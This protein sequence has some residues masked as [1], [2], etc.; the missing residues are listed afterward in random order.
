MS[1]AADDRYGSAAAAAG[2]PAAVYAGVPVHEWESRLAVPRFAA[3]ETVGSTLDAAHV[4]A[5]AGAQGGT[6]VVAAHQ[7]AG[8]GR[9]GRRWSS[10]A[11]TGVW[12]TLVERDVDP[13]ALGVLSLRAGLAAAAALDAFTDEPIR[14]KWPNDLYLRTGKLAG[15]LVEARWRGPAL[16]WVAIGF[17]VNLHVPADYPGAAALEPG[18]AAERVLETLVPAL[19]AAATA[20]GEL[21]VGELE[22][23]AGRDLARG[24]RCS[25]PARGR[26]AGISPGGALLV[27]LADT[28]VAV[29]TGSLVLE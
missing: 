29:R 22:E 18:T 6:V 1:P 12:L 23:Y 13:A 17:G 9:A 25:E 28:T 11:G 5:A 19:R 27:E 10:P 24:R 7:S 16:D 14:I 3:Y 4:L 2:V 15:T 8:R 20:T 21:T 26:V